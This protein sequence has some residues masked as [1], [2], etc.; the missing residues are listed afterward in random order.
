MT[1]NINKEVLLEEMALTGIKYIGS[2]TPNDNNDSRHIYCVSGTCYDN[3][4]NIINYKVPL[5][6]SVSQ[7]KLFPTTG[8]HL[9]GTHPKNDTGIFSQAKL[10]E[11]RYRRALMDDPNARPEDNIYRVQGGLRPGTGW[12]QKAT[13]A[14]NSDNGT[15]FPGSLLADHAKDLNYWKHPNVHPAVRDAVKE[16]NE[17]LQNHPENKTLV[18]DNNIEIRKTKEINNRLRE[19]LKEIK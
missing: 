14:V 2:T 18:S 13:V 9:Q 1:L 4:N 10:D 8:I 5:Y 19:F 3:N 17:Y 16:A 15:I 11:Y 6:H 12:V 7:G